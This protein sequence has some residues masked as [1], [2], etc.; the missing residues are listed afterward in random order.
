MNQNNFDRDA[1]LQAVRAWITRE[2]DHPYL[3][4]YIPIPVL[5]NFQLRMAYAILQS[6]AVSKQEMETVLTT[7]LLMHHGLD[8]HQKID[9]FDVRDE[10][11]HRQLGVLA[12]DYYSSKFFA[13]LAQNGNVKLIGKFAAAVSRINEAKVARD[14]LA[15]R[16]GTPREYLELVTR[17]NAEL[18]LELADGYEMLDSWK[19]C[20]L[21]A[22]Q[23]KAA[24]Q[25]MDLLTH[26]ENRGFGYYFLS[27]KCSASERLVLDSAA[28]IS[29]EFTRIM[30]LHVKY[31][32]LRSLRELVTANYQRTVER[33][34]AVASGTA[35]DFVMRALEELTR[36]I[37]EPRT[38]EEG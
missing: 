15:E 4:S 12:G 25:E 37:G 34:A 19:L 26:G 11:R 27:S 2:M 20:I 28:G 29:K 3:A 13:L 35:L 6:A 17:I 5:D 38:V 8:V 30:T 23:A 22:C 16:K 21:A 14:L 18:L 7:L 24:H 32:T 10:P 31:G 33:L 1:A 36:F 9:E